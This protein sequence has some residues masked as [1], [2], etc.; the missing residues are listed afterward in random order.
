[1][2]SKAKKRRP[3]RERADIAVSLIVW[4]VAPYAE[5][6]RCWLAGYRAA[7]RDAKRKEKS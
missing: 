7:K 6:K 1:M 3:L 2:A 4:G 5:G